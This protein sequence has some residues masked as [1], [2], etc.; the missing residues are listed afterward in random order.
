MCGMVVGRRIA[1]NGATLSTVHG[2]CF[3]Q[4]LDCCLRS[5]ATIKYRKKAVTPRHPCLAEFHHERS[6]RPRAAAPPKPRRPDG[7][8]NKEETMVG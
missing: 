7:W 5:L 2:A 3:V 1:N 6:A 4:L 8:G